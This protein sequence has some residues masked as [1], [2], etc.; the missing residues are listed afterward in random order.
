MRNII[1]ILTLLLSTQ[2]MMAQIVDSKSVGD[3]NGFVDSK[4]KWVGSNDYWY[5]SWWSD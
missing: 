5:T 2:S 3:Q 1:M 4:G